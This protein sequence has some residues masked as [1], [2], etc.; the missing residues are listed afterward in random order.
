MFIHVR[1]SGAGQE[2]EVGNRPSQQTHIIIL[3]IVVSKEPNL[4]PQDVRRKTQGTLEGKNR[5]NGG[6]EHRKAKKN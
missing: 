5:L 1:E 6:T 4:P 3:A 2:S